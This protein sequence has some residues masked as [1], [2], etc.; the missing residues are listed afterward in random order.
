MVASCRQVRQ[1][2]S[3]KPNHHIVFAASRRF[4]PNPQATQYAAAVVAGGSNDLWFWLD[5][6]PAGVEPEAIVHELTHEWR[7]NNEVGTIS[8]TE[9]HCDQALGVDQKMAL[10]S[11]SRCTMTSNMYSESS[12]R[13]GVVGFHYSK[14]AAGGP[15]HSEYMHIRHR[16]EPIPQNENARPEPPQ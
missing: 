7:V 6:I 11:S 12:A 4:E 5:R 14:P 16:H 10:H 8:F 3:A 9:G 13:D 15:V 1:T 2:V